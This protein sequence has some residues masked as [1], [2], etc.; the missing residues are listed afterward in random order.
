MKSIFN[1]E[2]DHI[3]VDDKIMN[4][5]FN[6]SPKK[7]LSYFLYQSKSLYVSHRA[8]KIGKML[9][10]AI[11]E[12]LANM[13]PLS[14]LDET[15]QSNSDLNDIFI[16]DKKEEEKCE[17][18]KNMSKLLIILIRTQRKYPRT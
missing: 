18:S 16:T 1:Q 4:I 13:K 2:T 14:Q 9:Q 8:L 5:D 10:E 11:Q 7:V 3:K 15:M 12:E 6:S 17:N